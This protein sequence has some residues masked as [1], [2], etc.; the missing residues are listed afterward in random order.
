MQIQWL[1]AVD[2]LRSHLSSEH[3]VIWAEMLRHTWLMTLLQ[4]Q[5]AILFPLYPFWNLITTLKIFFSTAVNRC[6]HP[7]ALLR[8]SS[9]HCRRQ[10]YDAV[11]WAYSP[12]ERIIYSEWCCASLFASVAS[13]PVSHYPAYSTSVWLLWLPR[14]HKSTEHRGGRSAIKDY[15]L[16]SS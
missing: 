13:R 5:Q 2:G 3:E 7:S 8:V 15:V 1:P 10:A 4:M 9:I 14:L 6:T 12:L 11:N 16:A